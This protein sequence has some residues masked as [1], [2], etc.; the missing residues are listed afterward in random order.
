[1]DVCVGVEGGLTPYG[2]ARRRCNVSA[3]VLL[4]SGLTEGLSA[5]CPHGCC[6]NIPANSV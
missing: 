4:L 1:M 3:C 5:T 2:V 6:T